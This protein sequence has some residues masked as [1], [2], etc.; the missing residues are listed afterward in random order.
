MRF[1]IGEV[2]QA[3]AEDTKAVPASASSAALFSPLLWLTGGRGGR[4]GGGGGGEI[5]SG[6]AESCDRGQSEQTTQVNT[7]CCRQFSSRVSNAKMLLASCFNGT[8]VKT[9]A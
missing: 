7:K 8:Q 9:T 5:V 2:C 3:K 1:C 6:V 4:D